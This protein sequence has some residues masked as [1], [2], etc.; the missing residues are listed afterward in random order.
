[1]TRIRAARRLKIGFILLGIVGAGATGGCGRQ[2]AIDAPCVFG[3]ECSA[4]TAYC[5]AP[6][7]PCASGVY[8]SM[9]GI[10]RSDRFSA[11]H[12]QSCTVDSDCQSPRLGCSPCDPSFNCPTCPSPVPTCAVGPGFCDTILCLKSTTPDCVPPC[13]VGG[14]CNNLSIYANLCPAGTTND[15]GV[16]EAETAD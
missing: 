8:A 15:A 10:C 16:N 1:M 4:G 7:V 2:K 5:D 9:G 12:L 14:V 13:H 6:L 11:M 3:D